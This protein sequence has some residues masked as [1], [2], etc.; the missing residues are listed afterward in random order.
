MMSS[1]AWSWLRSGLVPA[2]ES[3]GMKS[4]GVRAWYRDKQKEPE[5]KIK[6]SVLHQVPTSALGRRY[7][8]P[9]WLDPTGYRR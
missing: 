1:P 6:A 7:G 5:K 3:P 9:W 4:R 8:G 2:P